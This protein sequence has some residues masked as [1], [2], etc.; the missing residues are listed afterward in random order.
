MF[1]LCVSVPPPVLGE[2]KA[3]HRANSDHPKIRGIRRAQKL[4]VSSSSFI[5]RHS[6]VANATPSISSDVHLEHA[7]STG[8]HAVGDRERAERGIGGKAG[9]DAAHPALC[10]HGDDSCVGRSE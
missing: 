3:L 7:S 10:L 2:G 8:A 1:P 4:W 9:V 5:G 6:G